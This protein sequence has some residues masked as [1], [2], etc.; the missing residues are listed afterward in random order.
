MSEKK[1]K[2]PVQKPKSISSYRVYRGGN[3]NFSTDGT[4]A[5]GRVNGYPSDRYNF[6]GFRLA[7]TKK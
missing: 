4:R 6:I 1:P 2:N 5:S 3:W 7:R